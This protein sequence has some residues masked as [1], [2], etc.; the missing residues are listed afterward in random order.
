MSP[1]LPCMAYVTTPYTIEVNLH[2]FTHD[3]LK[4]L[5]SGK[6]FS[7]LRHF[8]LEPMPIKNKNDPDFSMPLLVA[9]RRFELRAPPPRRWLRTRIL[10]RR[11]GSDA[12]RLPLPL[13]ARH[14][15]FGNSNLLAQYAKR[16]LFRVS[17]SFLV[18]AR[19]FELPTPTT[20]R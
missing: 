8:L 11:T 5:T 6:G 12:L 2:S 9:P 19:R 3:R 7:T 13:P 14:R 10:L 16:T 18:G 15:R 17:F 20:P 1:Q 4:P